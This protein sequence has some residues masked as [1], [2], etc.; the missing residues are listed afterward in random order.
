MNPLVP[1]LI[2][3]Q[4]SHLKREQMNPEQLLTAG[5]SLK[6]RL[7]HDIKRLSIPG[8]SLFDHMVMETDIA[9]G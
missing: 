7:W 5:T 9:L 3:Y 8:E 4:T 1:Q 6:H 2:N